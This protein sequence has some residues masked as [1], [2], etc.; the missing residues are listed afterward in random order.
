MRDEPR[1]AKARDLVISRLG[2]GF[3]IALL[4]TR[5]CGKTQIAAQAAAVACRAGRT[6]LYVRAM[7]FF[8]DVRSTFRKEAAVTEADIIAKYQ[9]PKLLIIDEIQDRGDSAWENRLLTHLIDLRYGDMTDTLL[10]GNL[11]PKELIKHVRE[12]IADRMN[13]CGSII[14]CQWESFRQQAE[15]PKEAAGA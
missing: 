3:L 6:S 13:E 4:G 15:E 1:W 14:D 11:D 8:V 2:Q 5:G 9:S 12:S 10:I 7:T